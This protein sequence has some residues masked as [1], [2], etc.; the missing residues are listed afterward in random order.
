M[1]NVSAM[2]FV[3]SD[4]T[5]SFCSRVFP[6]DI[7]IVMTGI[8]IL[9][10]FDH[11]RG[12]YTCCISQATAC[13]S[14]LYRG[15]IHPTGYSFKKKSNDFAL[16]LS[17]PPPVFDPP[18]RCRLDIEAKECTDE[19]DYSESDDRTYTGICGNREVGDIAD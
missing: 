16:P 4:A 11:K 9:F 3:T 17:T 13:F 8:G 7:W 18:D 14:M 2:V 10:A 1:P 19:P 6:S 12:L 5:L 15:R